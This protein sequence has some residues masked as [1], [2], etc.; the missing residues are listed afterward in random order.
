MLDLA[1]LSFVP[2]VEIA[3]FWLV[4]DYARAVRVCATVSVL[5]TFLAEETSTV[6]HEV[7]SMLVTDVALEL[8]H[9]RLS[10]GPILVMPSRS[11]A[12][13]LGATWIFVPS[14]SV[15]RVEVF[16]KRLHLLQIYS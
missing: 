1:K 8:S 9:G 5:E 11:I 4:A 10:F 16:L 2:Q 6:G 15:V 12:N 3:R 7:A 13:V 14:F